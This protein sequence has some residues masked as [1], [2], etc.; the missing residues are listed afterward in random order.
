MSLSIL[1]N[2]LVSLSVSTIDYVVVRNYNQMI[3][4]QDLQISIKIF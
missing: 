1:A 3:G 2:F 4:I